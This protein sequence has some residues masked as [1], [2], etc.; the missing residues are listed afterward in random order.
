MQSLIK[1]SLVFILAIC[2]CSKDA[3]ERNPYIPEVRFKKVI[4][5]N[6]PL[7]S[8]LKTPLKPVVI[9]SD[10]VGIRG[11]VVINTGRNFIAW[12]LACPHKAISDCSSMEVNDIFAICPCDNTKFSLV[13]GAVVQGSSAYQM[14]NYN[15]SVSGNIITISN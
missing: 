9:N 3:V 1:I 14:L 6:L 5:T 4:N 15:V 13:N 7:Y 11:I 10:G 12:E 8:D 2:S